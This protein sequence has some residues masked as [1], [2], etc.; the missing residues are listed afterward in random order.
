MTALVNVDGTCTP[1]TLERGSATNGAYKATI[2][3]VGSGCHRY[4]FLFKDSSGT[5]VL[6]PTTGS[7]GIGPA[8]SCADW[9]AARPTGSTNCD[10][11]PPDAG[12]SGGGGSGGGGG[13]GN[14]GGLDSPTDD[15]AGGCCDAGSRSS[16]VTAVLLSLAVLALGRRRRTA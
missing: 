13:G 4:Y 3:G 11:V 9:D 15:A 14:D 5:A 8:G 6:Y 2:S 16:G 10:Y 1:M 12:G 7:L